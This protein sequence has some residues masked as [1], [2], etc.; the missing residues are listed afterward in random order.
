MNENEPPKILNDFP[1]IKFLKHREN[2][3]NTGENAAIFV[4]CNFFG[5]PKS[6]KSNEFWLISRFFKV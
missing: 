4:K 3:K 5:T 1:K 2:L 6:E